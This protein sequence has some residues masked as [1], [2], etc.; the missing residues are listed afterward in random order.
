L[1]P[2]H[3]QVYADKT[4]PVGFG[5]QTHRGVGGEDSVHTATGVTVETWQHIAI[6][7]VGN[8]LWLFEGGTLVSTDTL[9][10]NISFNNANAFAIGSFP[11]YEST[12]GYKGYLDEIRISKG[13]ARWTSNFTPPTQAYG[14]AESINILTSDGTNVWH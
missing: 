4:S 5:A 13:I 3:F 11:A 6:E 2:G 1:K 8:Q 14:K 9:S 12:H 10:M 7:R